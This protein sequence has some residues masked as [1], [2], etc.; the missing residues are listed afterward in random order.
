M[1]TKLIVVIN[2]PN[3]Y[4]GFLFPKGVVNLSDKNPTKGVDVASEI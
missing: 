4:H 2:Q 3:K 1:K